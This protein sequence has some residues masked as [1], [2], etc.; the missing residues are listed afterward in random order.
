M[1]PALRNPGLQRRSG[2]DWGDTPPFGGEV[3]GSSVYKTATQE[4]PSPPMLGG[5]FQ[6]IEDALGLIGIQRDENNMLMFAANQ[7]EPTSAQLSI[8]RAKSKRGPGGGKLGPGQTGPGGY[9][10]GQ[11]PAGDSGPTSA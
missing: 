2:V 6:E 11:D 4:S 9:P 8:Q 7:F 10:E 5:G 3:T 1:D